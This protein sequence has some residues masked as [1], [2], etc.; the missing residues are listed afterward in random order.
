MDLLVQNIVM[1]S[2]VKMFLLIRRV[3]FLHGS[4]SHTVALCH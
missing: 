3:P 2:E 4:R 1:D